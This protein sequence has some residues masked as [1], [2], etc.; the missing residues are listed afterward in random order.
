MEILAENTYLGSFIFQMVILGLIALITG[1]LAIGVLVS[2]IKD[3]GEFGDYIGAF[4][5]AGISALTIT[6]IIVGAKIGPEVEYTAIVSDYNEVYEQ[7]YE[8]KKIDGK[9]V[10]LTK[11]S[12]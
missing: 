9:L 3:G 2:V 5:M 4:G 7:G 8:V 6:G 10:T 12:R 1:V 11:G